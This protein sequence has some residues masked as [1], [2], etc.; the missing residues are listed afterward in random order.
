V[1]A[2]GIAAANLHHALSHEEFAHGIASYLAVFYA[3]WWAWMNFT[4]FAT[5]FD[6][7]DWLYRV[8]TIAQMAGVLVLAAGIGP[9]FN[10]HDFRTV[11]AG[12]VIM[13]LVMVAQWLRASRHAGDLRHATLVYAWG[14]AG[15]QALWIAWQWVP[16]GAA[17]NAIWLVIAALE[18]SVPVIA[19]RR[20]QT[21]WHP[22]HITE[23]YGLFTL[24]VLGESLLASANAIIEAIG[25]EADVVPLVELGALA[26]VVTGGLW[27]I[28]FWPPHHRAIGGLR[29]SLPYGYGH[30]VVF[31]SAAAFSA[32]IEV[33]IDVLTGESSLGAVAAGLCVSAPVAVFM[34]SVW[35]LA[36]R[37]VA[38]RVV[39]WAVPL[40]A[41]LVILDPVIP[42]PFAAT[43]VIV[44]GVVA[45][46]VVRPPLKPATA[47]DRG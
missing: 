22:H 25:G 41:L 26:L 28:Y 33:E 23:R 17:G 31:A 10:D 9:A 24:I 3:I 4:W 35:W 15:V 46:L 5:S 11:A 6:T 12:Y 20:H 14:I 7:D 21:P 32:G 2:V 39:N 13:R 45:V 40:G 34:L 37:A 30:F 29:Q 8:M 27:W 1:V 43:A 18:L 19:E 42:T 16:V 44:A 38:D 47:S 36:I